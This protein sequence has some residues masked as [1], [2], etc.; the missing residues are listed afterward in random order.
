MSDATPD[1]KKQKI[2]SI[3]MLY[4]FDLFDNKQFPESMKEFMKLNTEP[5]EVIKLFPELNG[6]KEGKLRGK[7]LENALNALIQ[8][9][10]EVRLMIQ[11]NKKKST[12]NGESN[13]R[14][15]EAQLELIDTT[16]LKCYL[17]VFIHLHHMFV[18]L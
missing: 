8:Y 3:Q 11:E 14:N 16:L 12:Q 1:E 15:A 6:V 2:H 10:R 9:L 18:T 7:D 5:A 4:A 17:Q 13:G